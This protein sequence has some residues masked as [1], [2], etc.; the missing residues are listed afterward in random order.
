MPNAMIG[1]RQESNWATG[2]LPV[3]TGSF[4]SETVV[5]TLSRIATQIGSSINARGAGWMLGA[6]SKSE[7]YEPPA[8]APPAP[9]QP[10]LS[11]ELP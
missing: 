10:Q 5:G 7:A 4:V 9:T 8:S 11:L 3:V 6:I 2:K 1:F